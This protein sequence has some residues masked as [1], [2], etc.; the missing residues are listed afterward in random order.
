VRW[1]RA[2]AAAAEDGR[3]AFRVS[4]L[5]SM[6]LGCRC[7]P[8]PDTRHSQAVSF[9]A[10]DQSAAHAISIGPHPSLLKWEAE[11]SVALTPHSKSKSAHGC[12]DKFI[13]ACSQHIKHTQSGAQ[14]TAHFVLFSSYNIR[15]IY[16]SP[17]E[18][19]S[20]HQNNFYAAFVCA[21]NDD[22]KM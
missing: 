2:L 5:A 12:A 16:I 20:L 8:L 14:H 1:S 17:L 7:H 18:T 19:A 13:R 22:K 11:A 4:R 6:V 21:K 10:G 15:C 3:F 9:A